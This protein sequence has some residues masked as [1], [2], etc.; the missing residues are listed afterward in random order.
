MNCLD[1]GIYGLSKSHRDCGSFLSVIES[2]RFGGNAFS[3]K[4]RE[5][6]NKFSL[7]RVSGKYIEADLSFG[8]KYSV[9]K[10][11]QGGLRKDKRKYRGKKRVV[12]N[13]DNGEMYLTG[14]HYNTMYYAGC[15]KPPNKCRG[16]DEIRKDCSKPEINCVVDPR[17]ILGESG[18]EILNLL[19]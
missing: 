17:F 4:I 13:Q 7:P 11:K 3:N 12:I 15:V 10:N 14:D 1:K 6:D 2:F 8:L 16:I 5:R 18:E 19:R 9:K